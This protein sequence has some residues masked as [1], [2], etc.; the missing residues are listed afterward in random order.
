MND[1]IIPPDPKLAH[2]SAA[3]Q[4]HLTRQFVRNP[5]RAV[6]L[7]TKTQGGVGA[8]TLTSILAY[9]F[10]EQG[11]TVP[12]FQAG[13][14]RGPLCEAYTMPQFNR[15]PLNNTDGP[16]LDQQLSQFLAANSGEPAIA[17]ISPEVNAMALSIVTTIHNAGLPIQFHNIHL[18]RPPA[19]NLSMAI[20]LRPFCLSS[21]V[22]MVEP[23]SHY[24]EYDQM[25]MIP[26]LP[27]ALTQMMELQKWPFKTAM[28]NAEL[29]MK[30]PLMPKFAKFAREL[31]QF[32]G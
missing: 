27:E 18:I 15:V 11:V 20:Q 5:A 1:I 23:L 7:I 9:V 16:P 25:L 17:V 2:M 30:I 32:Y 29:G 21:A 31:G 12:I 4:S 8:D 10:G 14:A 28:E 22:A 26:R 19:Q 24:P 3:L 13:G 6:T